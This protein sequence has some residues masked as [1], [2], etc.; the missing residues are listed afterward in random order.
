[1]QEDRATRAK[2]M[3]ARELADARRLAAAKAARARNRK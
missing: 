1:V 3:S 2:P